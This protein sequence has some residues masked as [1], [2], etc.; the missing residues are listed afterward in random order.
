MLEDLTK[1][2]MGVTLYSMLY[3]TPISFCRCLFIL[4]NVLINFGLKK[5]CSKKH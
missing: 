5:L 2:L 1:D 4:I 3:T